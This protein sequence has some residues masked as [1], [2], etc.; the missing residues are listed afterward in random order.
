MGLI[1]HAL[2]KV[3]LY[4]SIAVVKSVFVNH[5]ALSRKLS[6]R[7]NQLK[8]T[9]TAL[10]EEIENENYPVIDTDQQ[11]LEVRYHRLWTNGLANPLQ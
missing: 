2:I 7:L 4:G 9:V 10:N 6:F 5:P 8:S 11:A 1:T 3:V